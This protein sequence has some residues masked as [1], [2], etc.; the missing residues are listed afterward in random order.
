[1]RRDVQNRRKSTY[2]IFC[3]Y[4]LRFSDKSCYSLVDEVGLKFA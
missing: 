2:F 3:N 4:S 1:M